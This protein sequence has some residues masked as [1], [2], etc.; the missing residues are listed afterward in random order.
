LMFALIH[1]DH[2]ILDDDVEQEVFAT[3]LMHITDVILS[4]RPLTS[5]FSRE[6]HGQLS[7]IRG[8]RFNTDIT[9]TPNCLH[10]R[11]MDTTVQFFLPGHPSSVTL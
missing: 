3:S 5:G 7:L 4:V 9:F 2:E 1:A 8:P 11:I 10:Y 6:V